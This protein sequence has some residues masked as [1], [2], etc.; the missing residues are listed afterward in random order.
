MIIYILSHTGILFRKNQ[1]FYLPENTDCSLLR[2]S[3]C[4]AYNT[5]PK[6]PMSHNTKQTKHVT[7]K[8]IRSISAR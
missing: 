5:S 2:K 7:G 6:L 1:I 3:D 8:T 4:F